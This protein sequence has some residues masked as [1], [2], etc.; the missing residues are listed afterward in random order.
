MNIDDL[1]DSVLFGNLDEGSRRTAMGEILR[2]RLA[3]LGKD[4]LCQCSCAN[5]CPLEKAGSM[6][7]CSRKDLESRGKEEG[8]L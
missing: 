4:G 1:E 2:H 7:R 5:V 3:N 6:N 8:W